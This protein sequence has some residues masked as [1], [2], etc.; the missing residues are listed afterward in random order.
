M[1][2][3]EI[4]HQIHVLGHLVVSKLRLSNNRKGNFGISYPMGI[5]SVPSRE[6][7]YFH[8]GKGK[9]IDSKVPAG[10]GYGSSQGRSD[11]PKHA[12]SKKIVTNSVPLFWA[13]YVST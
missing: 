1:E 3:P 4:P 10:K 12:A 9:I 8:L 2:T 13:K 6:P 7:R 5:R 11:L